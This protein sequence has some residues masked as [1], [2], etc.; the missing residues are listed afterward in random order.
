MMQAAK[1]LDWERD[2]YV[3]DDTDSTWTSAL[4]VGD[5][6]DDMYD[7]LIVGE[8]DSVGPALYSVTGTRNMTGVT[9]A[10]D[11]A[12]SWEEARRLAE[13]EARRASIRLVE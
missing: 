9:F 13:I 1:I 2:P 5:R 12:D 3:A 6:P 8:P 7:M 11:T 4:I 10:R